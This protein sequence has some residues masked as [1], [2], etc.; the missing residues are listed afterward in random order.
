MTKK[1]KR[2]REQKPAKKEKFISMSP[3]EDGRMPSLRDVIVGRETE[4]D[5]DVESADEV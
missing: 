1:P 2:K 3:R 5:Y 4:D